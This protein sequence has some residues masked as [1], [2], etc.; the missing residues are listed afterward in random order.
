[1]S[2]NPL[3][4]RLDGVRK[5]G[6]GRWLA[7]CPAHDDDSP[8]LAIRELDN[9]RVLVHCFAECDTAA[10]LAAIGLDFDALFPAK[11]LNHRRRGEQRSFYAEDVL[12][13]LVSESQIAAIIVARVHAG[14]D[15]DEEEFD[16]L[17]VA[18][19]RIANGAT[20]AGVG[21]DQRRVHAQRHAA[22]AV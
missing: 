18:A 3:L 8:S 10:V 12:R 2:V 1:M 19:R 6:P 11:A 22:G 15:V 21:N 7:K 17:A 20:M 9:E 14:Y 5:T 13:A 16:R 4:S